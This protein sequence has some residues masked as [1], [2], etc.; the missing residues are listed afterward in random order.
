VRDHWDDLKDTGAYLE[1][2]LSSVTLMF[3]RTRERYNLKR[4]RRNKQGSTSAGSVLNFT[5]TSR[6]RS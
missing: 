4:N 1:C 3:P 5:V 6:K 2:L